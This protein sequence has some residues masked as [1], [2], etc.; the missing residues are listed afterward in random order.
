MAKKDISISVIAG[1]TFVLA[2]LF[3]FVLIIVPDILAVFIG[4]SIAA[5]LKKIGRLRETRPGDYIV[6]STF[7]IT[8]IILAVISFYATFLAIKPYKLM[9][10]GIIGDILAN[11]SMGWF[12]GFSEE[13]QKIYNYVRS[14]FILAILFLLTSYLLTGGLFSKLIDISNILSVVGLAMLLMNKI[15]SIIVFKKYIPL[16]TILLIL[17][18]VIVN[19]TYSA[20]Q[21]IFSFLG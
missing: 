10:I 17:S 2:L 20:L 5:Y 7:I 13:I 15:P 3:R 8:F 11:L 4:A 19:Y 18:K 14:F 12:M 1:I 6:I 16:I 9:I 21:P